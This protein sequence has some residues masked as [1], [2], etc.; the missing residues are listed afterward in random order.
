MSFKVILADQDEPSHVRAIRQ[1]WDD[2]LHFVAE[3]RY[4]WLYQDNPAGN[5]LTCL[6]VHE[7]TGKIIGTASAMRRNFHFRGESY[8]AG[9]AVDFAIDAEY[10]VFGPALLLQ[11]TLVEHA[12][13]EGLDFMLGFPNKASQGIIRR[14]GYE[15]IGKSIRFSRLIRTRSK[16]TAMLSK[17]NLPKLMGGPAATVLDAGLYLQNRISSPCGIP[18]IVESENDLGDYWRDFWDRNRA[19]DTFQGDH[20]EDYIR[21]R[22]LQCPYKNYRLF[23]LFEGQ[24]LV[25]FLVFSSG[26][27]GL[28]LVDDFCF[29]EEQ[30]VAPLFDHFW[31]K[32]RSSGN[33]VINVGL[34]IGTEIEKL[35]KDA[36]FIARPSERWGGILSNPDKTVDWGKVLAARSWYISD[37]E[38][39]L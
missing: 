17:W 38:I 28:V 7:E 14:L 19:I 36:G 21:W 24:R 31:R 15:Q 5:T 12:W 3:G 37:G 25:A 29:L 18:R 13:E 33:T 16:L 2:N 6:A 10:R 32:M 35:M 39:D 30:W 4:A 20:D 23:S 27:D 1:L 11:R 8:K 22:Y 34:V 9:I 26:D